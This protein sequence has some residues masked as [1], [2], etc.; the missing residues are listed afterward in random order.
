MRGFVLPLKVPL[1]TSGWLRNGSSVALSGQLCLRRPLA[2]LESHFSSP[3]TCAAAGQNISYTCPLNN[4][5]L[6]TLLY[7]PQLYLHDNPT[8][9]QLA[10]GWKHLPLTVVVVHKT[11]DTVR[12][13]SHSD[14]KYKGSRLVC[15]IL[16]STD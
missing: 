12:I 1:W 11:F 10:L 15:S 6:Y 2:A 8:F 16:L 5:V 3:P 14:V 13:I 4:A 7:I 9:V